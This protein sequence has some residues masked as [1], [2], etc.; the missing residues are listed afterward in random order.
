MVE[1]STASSSESILAGSR[2]Y[3]GLTD[4]LSRLVIPE[5]TSRHHTY[6]YHLHRMSIDATGIDDNSKI[7]QTISQPYSIVEV[8]THN[9]C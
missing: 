8:C 2:R 1:N 6:H 3:C 4:S 7:V 9:H 5:H